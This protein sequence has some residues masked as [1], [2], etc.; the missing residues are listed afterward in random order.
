MSMEVHRPQ[1]SHHTRS[2][3]SRLTRMDHRMPQHTQSQ[4]QKNLTRHLQS[5]PIN[6]N[7]ITNPNPSPS[8]NTN[9]AH[10]L[11][12]NPDLSINL[13][14]NISQSQN[15]SQHIIKDQL[16]KPKPKPTYHQRP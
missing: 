13:D 16:T 12:T 6:L 3:R 10:A 1:H 4:I 15:P 8:Q 7:L 11:S 2:Q 14:P 5:L 9:L